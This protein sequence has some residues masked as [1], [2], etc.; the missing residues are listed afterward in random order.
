LGR[1]RL[2]E[3]SMKETPSTLP[4]TMLARK[5]DQ[6][7][8]LRSL[9]YH[10]RDASIDAWVEIPAAVRGSPLAWPTTINRRA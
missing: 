4:S 7:I 3:E 2:R 5:R 6:G 10:L 8:V 1:V 9:Y